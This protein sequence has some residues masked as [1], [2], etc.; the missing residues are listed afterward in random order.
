MTT[1]PPIALGTWDGA[2]SW[3]LETGSTEYL[4]PRDSRRID[5]VELQAPDGGFMSLTK[6]R[7]TKRE[8]V[9]MHA[10]RELRRLVLLSSSLSSSSGC[11]IL[12]MGASRW[13]KGKWDIAR[14]RVFP[15]WVGSRRGILSL[16]G[17][18]RYYWCSFVCLSA[19]LLLFLRVLSFYLP[20]RLRFIALHWIYRK[21]EGGDLSKKTLSTNKKLVYEDVTTTWEVDCFILTC[22]S[23]CLEELGGFLGSRFIKSFI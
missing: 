4:I 21:K 23:F 14:E 7:A 22:V 15:G 6:E 11:G 12:Q 18:E 19:C 5:A 13:D 16:R 17:L 8:C 20:P 1:P 3:R 10:P 9:Y 2:A